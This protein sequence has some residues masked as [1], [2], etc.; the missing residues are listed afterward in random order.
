MERKDDEE[1]KPVKTL[2]GSQTRKYEEEK[3]W[4][5]NEMTVY[6]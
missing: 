3:F 4:P 2:K 5:Q 6:K 1:S